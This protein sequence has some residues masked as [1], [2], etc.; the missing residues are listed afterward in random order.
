MGGLA[1]T[2]GESAGQTDPSL[3]RQPMHIDSTFMPLAP[4]K[5]LVNPGYCDIERLPAILK[6]SRLAKFAVC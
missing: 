1:S 3:C 2:M 6:K 5:V 4:G